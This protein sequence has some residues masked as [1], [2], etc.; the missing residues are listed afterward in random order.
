MVDQSAGRILN[1]EFGTLV[2]FDFHILNDLIIVPKIL[3]FQ[4]LIFVFSF[5]KQKALLDKIGVLSDSILLLNH[6]VE[7]NRE[8]VDKNPAIKD[9]DDGPKF[10]IDMIEVFVTG[11]V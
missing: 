8:K 1:Y 2:H 11:A 5:Q 10:S 7:P 3:L 9:A 4:L 6:L